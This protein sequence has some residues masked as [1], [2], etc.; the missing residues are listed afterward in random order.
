MSTA[1]SVRVAGGDDIDVIVALCIEA[2]ETPQATEEQAGKIARQVRAVLA[3]PGTVSLLALADDDAAGFALLRPLGPSALYD[4]PRLQVEALYVRP[5]HRRR[6]L[7]RALMRAAL[8]QAERIEAPDVIVLP[9]DGSRKTERFLAQLG[10]VKIASHRVIDTETLATR[11]GPGVTP[12]TSRAATR[13]VL[14]R[15]RMMAR[16]SDGSRS[17][18]Q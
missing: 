10:F 1:Q 18:P 14:A 15:R 13:Q 2:R 16:A 8:F 4:L 17:D 5:A 6:G 3:D 9:I 7:G 12:Q 11:L